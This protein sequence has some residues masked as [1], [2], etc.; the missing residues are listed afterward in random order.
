MG[1]VACDLSIPE[2]HAFQDVLPQVQSGDRKPVAFVSLGT[3]WSPACRYSW[4]TLAALL[5]DPKYSSTLEA[6][7]VNQ[8]NELEFCYSE[9]IPVG[10]PTLLVFVSGYLVT[11]SEEGMGFD[12]KKT[13][14]KN[15]LIRQL[16]PELIRIVADRAIDVLNEKTSVI[17][18]ANL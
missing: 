5:R 10:F 3:T 2:F 7:Y 16:N 12:A 9:G 8:D 17:S 14:Q 13:D 1:E 15:R 11:F 4:S 18:C 6:F